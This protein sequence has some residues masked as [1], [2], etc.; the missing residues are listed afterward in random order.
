MSAST[1]QALFAFE[2]RLSDVIQTLDP[3]Y[4]HRH[5]HL[6][7]LKKAYEDLSSISKDIGIDSETSKSL[8]WVIEKMREHLGGVNSFEVLKMVASRVRAIHVKMAQDSYDAYHAKTM[9]SIKSGEPYRAYV[10]YKSTQK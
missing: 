9:A 8:S 7:L 1:Y 3:G 10:S 6:S 2:T 4:A 5:I